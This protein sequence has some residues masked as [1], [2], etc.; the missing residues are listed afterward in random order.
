MN[1]RFGTIIEACLPHGPWLFS[2]NLIRRC[3]SASF[4]RRSFLNLPLL[5]FMKSLYIALSR[6]SLLNHLS[7]IVI[8]HQMTMDWHVGE[9]IASVGDALNEFSKECDGVAF[10]RFLH[11]IAEKRRVEMFRGWKMARRSLE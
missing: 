2:L 4:D 3:I 10:S 5:Q 1:G 8:S 7:P 9:D 11:C 6:I